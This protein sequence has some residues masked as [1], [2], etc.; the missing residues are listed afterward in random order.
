MASLNRFYVLRLLTK[1]E[2]VLDGP[3]EQ[4]AAAVGKLLRYFDEKGIDYAKAYQ[5]TKELLGQR[6]IVM[7]FLEAIEEMDGEENRTDS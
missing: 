6:R 4:R 1:V 7:A 5:I 3:P 2:K